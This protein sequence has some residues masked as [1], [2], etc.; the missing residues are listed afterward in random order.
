[1][2]LGYMITAQEGEDGEVKYYAIDRSSGGYPYWASVAGSAVI[3]EIEL[4]AA[5]ALS[6]K[7][8]FLDPRTT[9]DGTIYP[10][11]MIAG[12]ADL[13]NRKQ[14]S[15]VIKIV[16]LMTGEATYSSVHEVKIIH[17]VGE[18]ILSKAIQEQLHVDPR[19]ASFRSGMMYEGGEGVSF[20]QLA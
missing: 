11:S 5:N 15:V 10:P 7:E 20:V 4:A 8:D 6:H 1:M 16:P 2:L 19:V 18:G 9:S 14:S 17:G 3:F 13:S 12:A